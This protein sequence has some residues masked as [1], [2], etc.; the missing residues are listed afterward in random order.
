MNQISNPVIH[1]IK[2]K[3]SSTA[4]CSKVIHRFR[5]AAREV[6]CGVAGLTLG[7]LGKFLTPTYM[8]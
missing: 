6:S 1:G 2:L 3:L 8:Y 5:M 7:V 4:L